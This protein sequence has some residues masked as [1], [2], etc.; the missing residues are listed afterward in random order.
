MIYIIWIDLNFQYLSHSKR[1]PSPRSYKFLLEN[2][3]ISYCFMP[4]C[5][6][7]DIRYLLCIIAFVL[8]I[9]VFVNCPFP[10]WMS[11][12]LWK[13]SA[14]LAA[15]KSNRAPVLFA[16]LHFLIVIPLKIIEN[17]CK[18]LKIIE[19]HWKSLKIIIIT[20]G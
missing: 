6:V 17:Y 20:E 1:N 2:Q 9:L 16:L 12:L 8:Y 7:A 11:G 10:D 15:H 13:S 3:F 18:S 4:T 5:R 14:A 19:N